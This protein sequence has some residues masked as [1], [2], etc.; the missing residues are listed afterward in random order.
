MCSTQVHDYFVYDILN[1]P[2]VIVSQHCF[3]KQTLYMLYCNMYMYAALIINYQS[4]FVHQTTCGYYKCMSDLGN[5][6]NQ[7][8]W[9]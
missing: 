3:T 9:Q 4:I 8:D 6:K 7:I 5:A 2:K 1:V